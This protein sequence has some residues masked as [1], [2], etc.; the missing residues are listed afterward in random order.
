[1]IKLG[2]GLV[3]VLRWLPGAGARKRL[4]LLLAAG[5]LIWEPSRDMLFVGFLVPVAGIALP[6]LGTTSI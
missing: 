4:V 2:V 5:A 6:P 1:M 3:D